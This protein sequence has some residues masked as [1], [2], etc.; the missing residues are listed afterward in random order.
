MF[1][2]IYP[3]NYLFKMRLTFK[4]VKPDIPLSGWRH[5][6]NYCLQYQHSRSTVLKVNQIKLS[7][8]LLHP[9]LYTQIPQMLT[10]GR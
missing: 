8:C 1:S 5:F 3:F 7:I 6:L 9:N 2:I 4:I 10:D